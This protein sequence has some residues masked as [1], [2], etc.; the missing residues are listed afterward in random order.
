MTDMKRLEDIE[1]S[2]GAGDYH[3]E[4]DVEWLISEVRRLS[5]LPPDA[6]KIL[7]EALQAG[8][9]LIAAK[10]NYVDMLR[11]QAALSLLTP[12]LN[13]VKEL[14]SQLSAAQDVA[15]EAEMEIHCDGGLKARVKELEAA[16]KEGK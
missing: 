4:K 6:E 3:R 14:E 2:L 12:A 13:R 16:L 8:S 9:N 15:T 5:T 7:H 10:A 11:I 1:N